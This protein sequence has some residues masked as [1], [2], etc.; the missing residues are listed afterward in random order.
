[1]S[2]KVAIAIAAHPDDI[3]FMTMGTLLMLQKKGWEIHYMT[4][5]NGNCGTAVDD[6]AT[7]IRKRREESM[8]SCKLSGAIYHPSICNDLE[9]FYTKENFAK[10]ISV[11]REV[12]PQI[13]LT[14]SP[15]DYMEDHL[16]TCRLTIAGAF[17]RGML[18]APCDPPR[19]PIQDDT[20]IYHAIPHGLMDPFRRLIEPEVFVNVGPV[21]DMK[22]KLLECHVSQKE[23]LD[24]SQ[25][26]D[27]YQLTM[28]EFMANL[29]KRSGKFEFA[30]GFR[31]RSWLGFSSQEI[32]PLSEA[33]GDDVLPNPNYK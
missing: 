33:L 25:G 17:D 19:E 15:D 20:V 1:M 11:I 28:K 29:G 22:W 3:E 13:I 2:N 5:A 9:V 16:N 10:I 31:R 7:I 30:E 4:V 8:A 18:N 26:M 14:Q 12:K 32:D 6:S 21:M 27:A 24:V 23:W